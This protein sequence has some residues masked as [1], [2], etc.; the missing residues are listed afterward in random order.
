MDEKLRELADRL[1][2]ATAYT[3]CGLKAACHEVSDE[4][5]RFCRR[6]GI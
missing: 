4:T 3:D 6:S 5:V 2:I 1:G